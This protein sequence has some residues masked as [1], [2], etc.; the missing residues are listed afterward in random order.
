M[1]Y[2]GITGQVYVPNITRNEV[3]VLRPASA[4]SGGGVAQLPT[5]PARTLAVGGG[6]AAVAI[7]FDG[8]YGFVAQGAAGSVTMLDIAAHHTVATLAVGGKPRA[9]IP[10]S[11]PPLLGRQ[12]AHILGVLVHLGLA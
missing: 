7:T 11:L 5:E 2:D 12:A 4:P 8:A 9:L 3:A 1:D 10:R 6:P